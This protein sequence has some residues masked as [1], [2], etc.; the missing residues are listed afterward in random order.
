MQN[1]EINLTNTNNDLIT[2]ITLFPDKEWDWYHISKN[3]NITWKFIQENP[4]LPWKW[5]SISQ[6]PSITFEIIEEDISHCTDNG[7][8]WNWYNIT[9]NPNITWEI[10]QS[11]PNKKWVINAFPL[12]PN[13]T[14]ETYRDNIDSQYQYDSTN[15][16][17]IS[18][19][20][21]DIVRSN[22]SYDWNYVG[23]ITN[24][25][26]LKDHNLLHKIQSMRQIKTTHL[27]YLSSNPGLTWGFI[28]NNPLVKWQWKNISCNANITWEI[29]KSNPQTPWNWNEVIQNPNVTWEIVQNNKHLFEFKNIQLCHF[30]GNPNLTVDIILN[31]PDI[32]WKWLYIGMNLFKKHP[33]I[34]KKRRDI[35]SNI[36]QILSA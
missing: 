10:I 6:N 23:A 20:T 21:I 16:A 26:I 29:I 35:F 32:K 14:W 15:V 12:N 7:V 1:D 13:I 2:L 27:K 18:D 22:P 24:P 34:D 8:D 3:P 28:Q 19:L 9:R 11:N 4:T 5:Q 30:S 17:Y 33:V 36:F 31:N 25:N